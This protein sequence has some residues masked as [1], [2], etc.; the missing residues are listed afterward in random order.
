MMPRPQAIPERLPY[1]T[2]WIAGCGGTIK[3]RPEDFIVEE[4]PAYL[5]EGSG[6]HI[7]LWVEKRG[8]STAQA[9]DRLR[10]CFRLPAQAI[11]Y[12][13]LKDAQSVARQWISL[14]SRA[15]LPLHKAEGPGLRILAASRHSNKLRR[16]HLR[17][18]RFDMLVRGAIRPREVEQALDF[19]ARW[20][21]PNYYGEQRQGVDG[22]NAQRG[23]ALLLAGR[24]ASRPSPPP[25]FPGENNM[26][27]TDASRSS[28]AL[29]EEEQGI[30]PVTIKAHALRRHT[31]QDRFAINAY[32]AAL[33]NELVAHRL[34]IMGDLHTLING[35]LPLLHANGVFFH[36]STPNLAATQP[37]A[38][39]GEI[40]PSAP[41]YGYR[42]ELASGLPGQW[43]R[44][45]L[46][47]EKLA[48]EDFRLRS[49]SESP[50]GERRAVRAFPSDLAHEWI[51][52][53]DGPALRLQFS[54]PPGTYATALLRELMKPDIP[55]ALEHDRG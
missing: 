48:L 1:L 19:L 47:R 15:D 4:L 51:T 29:F 6:E 3:Q 45:L 20:G 32:Q 30:G 21:F 11:G 46:L 2:S 25:Q 54:L 37:R 18:N 35:D 33:F 24:S 52:E 41:L 31:D 5:P 39:A 50:G 42:V 8:I 13:G 14:H 7:Y 16:G 17:G 43:E 55:G 53:Q 40:S 10:K 9:I 34:R 22:R 49:K 36:V 44:A 26:L 27:A 38:E 28:P 23:K 12:A